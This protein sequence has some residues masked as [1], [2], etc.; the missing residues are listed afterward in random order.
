LKQ[1]KKG[2]RKLGIHASTAITCVKPSGTVSQLVDS[3]SGIHPRYSDYYIRTVR[4]DKKDPI[5]HF[6]KDQGVQVEDAIGKEDSTAIFSFPMKAPE[7][8]VMRD[9][10]SALEQL[11]LWKVY[12]EHWCEHKPSITV[13]VREDEW[14]KVGAWVYENFDI[15]SGVS[16]LPHS[17][18]SYK[19]APYQEINEEEY[20]KMV[21]EMPEIDWEGL[22]TFEQEDMTTGSQEYAC[23]GGACEIV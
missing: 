6:L 17:D 4:T 14:L 21:K 9:D 8:S 1:I 15:C 20:N 11:E 3:A 22:A 18:H 16:F 13:Y 12:A 23:V 7:G 10:R 19:Q 5:Y 2:Q